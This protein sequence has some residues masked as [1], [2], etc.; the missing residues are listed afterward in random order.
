[1]S[2]SGAPEI[3]RLVNYMVL[4]AAT[5]TKR[6]HPVFLVI[7]EFQRMLAS[8][9]EYM[10]PLARSTG[11]GVIL[12]NQSMEDLKKSTT[13]L[14]PDIEAN[15]RLRQWFS[16]S[17]CRS[18]SACRSPSRSWATRGRGERFRGWS[19]VTLVP[20]LRSSSGAT[21]A[22]AARTFCDPKCETSSCSDSSNSVVRDVRV[23]GQ[24]DRRTDPLSWLGFAPQDQ[25]PPGTPS[26]CLD[27]DLDPDFVQCLRHY[28]L[29]QPSI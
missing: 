9:L 22:K 18:G 1:L 10:L 27:G 29:V 21:L 23:I 26:M 24:S 11:V 17:R 13:N 6:R 8:N 28:H 19:F 5:Q 4:A 25:L 20:E 14:I 2:P 7:D 15:C 16:S 12:A 3:A